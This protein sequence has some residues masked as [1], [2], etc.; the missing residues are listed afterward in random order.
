M[1]E[2]LLPF[3]TNLVL[4][5]IRGDAL[6][7]AIVRGL[8]SR[9]SGGWLQ[10]GG[11]R[12]LYFGEEALELEQLQIQRSAEEPDVW[13]PIDPT[14][15]YTVVTTQFLLA[16]GDG[17]NLMVGTPLCTSIDLRQFLERAEVFADGPIKPPRGDRFRP[18]QAAP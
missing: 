10:V 5:R 14:A 4:V 17:Y 3:R 8:N 12:I 18:I 7:D 15:H 11:V 1:I 6:R 9:G 13:A 2:E 16:G